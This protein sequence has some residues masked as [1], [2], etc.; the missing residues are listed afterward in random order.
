M[1]IVVLAA[2]WVF[3]GMLVAPLVGA[4]LR[5]HTGTYPLPAPSPARHLV[6]GSVTGPVPVG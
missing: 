1:L 5:G 2:A 4:L 3:A 6:R